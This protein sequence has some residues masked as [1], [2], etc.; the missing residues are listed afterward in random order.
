MKMKCRDKVNVM[1]KFIGN[2]ASIF[3]L[4]LGPLATAPP[5]IIIRLLIIM[6]IIIKK[7][8]LTL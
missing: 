6:I 5:K 8:F 1:Y 7:S 3:H 2:N 4:P